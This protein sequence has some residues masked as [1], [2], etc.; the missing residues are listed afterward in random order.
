MTTT[1]RSTIQ[2]ELTWTWTDHVDTLPIVDSNRLRTTIDMP[3]GF[4]SGQADAVWHLSDQSLSV[5]Q[6]I[7]Y[8]LDR[9]PQDLFGSDVEIPM[10]AIKA[11]LISNK[12]T[13]GTGTLLVGG[14]ATNAWEE[15][16]GTA[17]DQ[18]T[19]PPGSPLLLANTQDGW[20]IPIDQTDLKVEAIDDDVTYDIAILGTLS[21]P[22]QSSSST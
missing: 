21:T 12:T 5:G 14:A 13:S 7:V 8:E 10:I 3:D 4:D 16:F 19:V 9:L 6:S 18:I 15:P 11:I 22:Q 1:L 17:G 2:A 20:L